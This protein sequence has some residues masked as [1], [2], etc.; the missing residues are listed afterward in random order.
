MEKLCIADLE[1]QKVLKYVGGLNPHLNQV[2][3]FFD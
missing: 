3:E 2:M 1:K